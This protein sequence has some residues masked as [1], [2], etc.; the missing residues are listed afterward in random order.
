MLV[1]MVMLVQ[2]K[3]FVFTETQVV[4]KLLA[5]FIVIVFEHHLELLNQIH[6]FL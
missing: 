3:F 5:V 1:I 4:I 6:G 2:M